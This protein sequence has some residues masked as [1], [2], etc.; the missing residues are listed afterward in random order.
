MI[1]LSHSHMTTEKKIALTIQTF[2]SK[3]ISLLFNILS[4]SVI[5]FL[6]RSKCLL[7]SW[8]QSPSTVILEPKK[9]KSV[10]AL[11]F[12]PFIYHEVTGP[13]TM[14]FIFE[15]WVLSQLF[16]P[17]KSFFSSFSLSAIKVV[18]YVYLRLLIFIPI[19]LI[20]ACNSSSLAF[21]MMYSTYK[22]NKQG[23]NIQPCL[24]P[25]LILNQLVVLCPVLTVAS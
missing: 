3:I 10:T 4:K 11:T 16:H 19:I 15:C 14:I 1:Q 5:V 18:S 8:L 21:R 23:D 13:D 22:W 9:M 6:P 2:V 7:I 24:I 20:P 12:P 17:I 25:F